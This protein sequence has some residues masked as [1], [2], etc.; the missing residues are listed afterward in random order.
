M[1]QF[2]EE[3]ALEGHRGGEVDDETMREAWR[4]AEELNAEPIPD[5]LGAG[6]DDDA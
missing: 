2:E 4:T 1:S 5:D 6:E 3:N